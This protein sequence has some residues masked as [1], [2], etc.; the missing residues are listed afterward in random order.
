LEERTSQRIITH[1][2]RRLVTPGLV[3]LFVFLFLAGP[4]EASAPRY[5]LVRLRFDDLTQLETWIAQGFD[6]WQVEGNTALVAIA[7]SKLPALQSQGIIEGFAGPMAMASFPACYR[8]YSD[9][10]TFLNDS[11]VRYPDLVDIIDGGDSWETQ[12]G[13][14]DRDL[15]VARLTSPRGPANKPK[16]FILAE[17]HAR[18][19]V[20]P[21]VAMAFMD[22][23]LSSYGSDPTATWVL[24]QREV[25]VMP[26]ANPD[27]HAQV[28]EAKNWRKNTRD[29]G[30]CLMGA[31]PNSQGVDLNRNFGFEWGLDA[32][33]SSD[34]CNLTYRGG[35]PFSEPENQGIRD[36]VLAER[37]DLVI[38]LHS[39]GDQILYP[40]AYTW[41]P[42][43]DAVPL[44]ALANRMVVGTD[45]TVKQ[46]SAGGYRASGDTID[47]S[48]GELGI[49][50]FTLEIGGIEDGMFWPSCDAKPALYQ[51]VRGGLIYA[52][53]AAGDPYGVAGGPEATEIE[54]SAN[55]SSF[56]VRVRVS[57]EW[58][59]SQ[60]IEGA[61]LYLEA[62]GERGAGLPLEPVDGDCAGST[63]WMT[64]DLDED[65][66]SRYAGQRV[67]LV[68]VA[69]DT[70]GQRGVP[71][72]AWLDLRDYAAPADQTVQIWLDDGPEP[73]YELRGRYVY[74][75]SA[76]SGPV[77]MTVADGRVYRGA[78]VDGELLFTLGPDWVR[79]SDAGPI[80]YSLRDHRL[81]DGP[82]MVGRELYRVEPHR[83]LAYGSSEMITVARSDVDL[84][85]EGMEVPC[86]LLPI[87]LE[88]R[89]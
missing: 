19:I 46:A 23:L 26:M 42:A 17:Q 62:P 7:T 5:S 29:T 33:A 31:P 2:P 60:A 21:E 11:A 4:L 47:W 48:Y 24:D 39:Y 38:S 87:L 66:L 59:G 82:D 30:T 37:F 55:G 45:Y 53:L 56:T 35:A 70:A 54:V 63:E 27:G 79:V 88:E 3:L 1:T 64:S 80:A 77:L 22:D 28:V 58:T 73:T 20:T 89:Y 6:V 51:E 61:E 69:E 52:A 9:L 16:L 32:G 84:T 65:L 13:E 43:P 10:R 68:V 25:W 83:L 18:E 75:G 86:L 49:P 85:A 41:D 74:G 34:P 78:G 40:W 57:D 81:F 15:W 50:S 72:L 71:A 12:G 8:T 44:R 67:P 36:L 14:A 76:E